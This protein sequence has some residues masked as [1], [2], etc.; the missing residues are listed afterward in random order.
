MLR[1]QAVDLERPEGQ[2]HLEAEVLLEL[3]LQHFSNSNVM[4]WDLSYWEI[5][6]LLL[7]PSLPSVRRVSS[8]LFRSACQEAGE[9]PG[10]PDSFSVLG[11]YSTASRNH[12]VNPGNIVELF[13]TFFS[14]S[15]LIFL[16]KCQKDRVYFQEGFWHLR[17]ARAQ[18][19]IRVSL[20]NSKFRQDFSKHLLCSKHLA[21][22]FWRIWSPGLT[23]K[24]LKAMAEKE[25]W[26][27]WDFLWKWL[28]FSTAIGK[29]G[30]FHQNLVSS[31][32]V[33]HLL[34]VRWSLGRQG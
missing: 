25:R 30:F 10:S 19:D 34:Q 26:A 11:K 28:R 32:A 12:E 23:L 5:N 6:P 4:S 31:C 3:S 8:C 33:Q 20:Q 21:G 18:N 2:C 16:S 29:F 13:C 14:F 24:T 22:M 9:V 1:S 17:L 27:S 15:L 7:E